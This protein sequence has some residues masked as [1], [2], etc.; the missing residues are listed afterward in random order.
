MPG[1]IQNIVNS[2]DDPKVSILISPRAV[3]CQIKTFVFAPI[4]FFVP[5]LVSIDRAQHRGP[6]FA[7]YQFS[8]P[9]RANLFS[10]SVD[11]RC[12]DSEKRERS[13]SWLGWYCA[14]QRRDHDRSC[15]RLPPSVD[16]RA[17]AAPDFFSI[18]HPSFG[19]DRFTNGPEE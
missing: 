19:I 2:T 1:N 6:R 17:A 16:H 10:R 9:I 7:D 15:F 13:A 11:N 8:T 5:C 3:T 12:I 14:R 18:P 4:L